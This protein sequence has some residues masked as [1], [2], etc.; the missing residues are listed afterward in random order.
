MLF[1]IYKNLSLFNINYF[2][3]INFVIFTNYLNKKIIKLIEEF[4]NLI[5]LLIIKQIN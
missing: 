3:I 2:L 5:L 1:L 4:Y